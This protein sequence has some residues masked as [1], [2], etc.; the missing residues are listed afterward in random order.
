MILE[1]FNARL[2]DEWLDGEIF[3]SL[4]QSRAQTPAPL[5]D[6]HHGPFPRPRDRRKAG[7]QP[8]PLLP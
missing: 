7:V 6:A 4:Q 8:A 2:R 3:Y 5:M 1:G